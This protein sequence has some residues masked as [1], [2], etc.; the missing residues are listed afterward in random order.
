MN[1]LVSAL[2]EQIYDFSDQQEDAKK[3]MKLISEET[4]KLAQATE[5]VQAKAKVLEAE[6][7]S[8]AKQASQIETKL[9]NVAK[10]N[11]REIGDQNVQHASEVVSAK[12]P[13]MKE[14]QKRAEKEAAVIDESS[15]AP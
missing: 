4:N 10:A 7:S 8:F 1:K 9:V 15:V 12:V 5:S 6:H 13:P 11:T 3:M 2:F 14:T